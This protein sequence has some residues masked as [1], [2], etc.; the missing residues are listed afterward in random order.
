MSLIGTV[1]TSWVVRPRNQRWVPGKSK[2]L[3]L[4]KRIETRAQCN[5]QFRVSGGCITG[6]TFLVDKLTIV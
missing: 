2:R 5:F 4:P 3:C 6:E 1:T